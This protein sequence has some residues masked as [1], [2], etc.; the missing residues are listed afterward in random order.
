MLL[1]GLLRIASG[2]RIWIRRLA[3][4]RLLGRLCTVSIGG[5]SCMVS[6]AVTMRRSPSSPA[7]VTTSLLLVWLTVGR[8]ASIIRRSGGRGRR[9]RPIIVGH[10]SGWLARVRKPMVAME[11]AVEDG[12][13]WEKAARKMQISFAL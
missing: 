11:F 8:V 1:M 6:A 7:A 2:R 12:G 3:V 10:G 4:W 13:C 9:R 5:R